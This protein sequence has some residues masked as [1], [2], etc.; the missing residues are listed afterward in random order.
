MGV[1][2]E[3]VDTELKRRVAIKMML[4]FPSLDPA[5]TQEGE[6]RFLR[7]ARLGAGLQKHP[8]LVCVHEAGILEGQRYMVMEFIDGQPFNLWRKSKSPPLKDQVR[9]LR[10]V[11]RAV[12]HAHE[13]GIIHRDLKPAN[14]LVDQKG[15]PHVTDLGLSKRV[16]QEASLTLSAPG[17]VVGTPAY[18]SPEQ[19]QGLK[20]VDR[21]TDIYSLGIVLYEILTGR[22]PFTGNSPVQIIMKI[23]QSDV[24]PPSALL[25]SLKETPD[26]ALEKI[27][28]QALAKNPDD[29]PATAALLADD[30]ARWLKGEEVQSIAPKPARKARL[31]TP[32]IVGAGIGGGLL[33]LAL[34]VALFSGG[35][36]KQ[37][38]LE[39]A[40]ARKMMGQRQYK[41][42]AGAYERALA[43]DPANSEAKEGKAEA[44]RLF[45]T[46][47]QTEKTTA[48]RLAAEAA[49]T[50]EAVRLKDAQTK[51]R[52]SEEARQKEETARREAE[53]KAR[54]EA[55][56]A[57][58]ER[59]RLEEL[60]KAKESE[61]RP[62]LEPA[63]KSPTPP[64]ALP[65]N[66][67]LPRLLVGHAGR[68]WG[69]AFGPQ[70][71]TLAS[72]GADGTVRLWEVGTGKAVHSIAAHS[73]EAKAVAFDPR[74]LQVASA[75]LDGTIKIWECETARQT[76]SLPGHPGGVD[77]IAF[78]PDGKTLVSG[79]RDRKVKLWD[80][81]SGRETRTLVGHV[82]AVTGVSFSP[83]GK[84]LASASADWTLRVWEVATGKGRALVGQEGRLESVA[85]SPVGKLLASG[86]REGTLRIWHAVL[87]KDLRPMSGQSGDILK[88]A[89]SPNGAVL[90]SS[91]VS[92]HI[93]LWE[94][95]SGKS[96]RTIDAG[97]RHAD[98]IAWS[99]DGATIAAAGEDGQVGLWDVSEPLDSVRFVPTPKDFLSPVPE[100]FKL[101]AS[102][103]RIRDLF[104]ADFARKAPADQ[105][106]LGQKLYTL[107]IETLLDLTDRYECLREASDLASGSGDFATALLAIDSLREVFAVDAIPMKMEALGKQGI[108]ER[109]AAEARLL[110]EAYLRLIDEALDED[111]YEKIRS[112]GSRLELAAKVSK[113][114]ALLTRAQAR[115][116]EGAALQGEHGHFKM[117]QQALK[118][119]PDEPSANLVAGKYL[120][121]IKGDWEHGLPML[122]KGSDPALRA[123]A[124]RESLAPA[125]GPDRQRLCEAW[126]GIAEHDRSGSGQ[127]ALERARFW[128]RRI[129]PGLDPATRTGLE[130]RIEA[131]VA[132][133]P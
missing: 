65:A 27:C 69:L 87:G 99:P 113:D 54:L 68:T 16:S 51:L 109:S 25:K 10:D 88:V 102:E 70:G 7:E 112:F 12:H 67:A 75:S 60:A 52:L 74:G 4:Q 79:G 24:T 95:A 17:A 40:R 108:G 64:P 98:T 2:Y 72:A 71:K 106:A 114:A 132:S 93:R 22:L 8:N 107:G 11:A 58:E 120:S 90:A 33:V 55:K 125:E 26:R 28:L 61:A 131:N 85:F 41:E 44:W 118:L 49:R 83:D 77:S 6:E 59:S 115:I 128:L 116:R 43:A 122:V 121:F 19:A 39:L 35:S 34:L 47:A 100:P 117:A 124:Q 97:P 38:Q 127:K 123:V 5:Q 81:A 20:T 31:A 56:V 3:A 110:A 13:Q 32:W 80:L 37:V 86:G 9:L 94:T 104:K 82:L 15:R 76:G 57:E 78:S 119:K 50:E 45:D 92:G 1:V 73:A 30:L 48:A 14:I 103:K 89:F 53:E 84:L 42:A 36:G 21:R 101:R 23:V 18:M 63:A 130:K 126:I 66:P 105:R 96:L 62:A 129:A 111:E 29:R 46:A 91:D 133:S